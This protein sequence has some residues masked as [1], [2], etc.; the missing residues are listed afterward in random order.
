MTKNEELIKLITEYHQLISQEDFEKIEDLC[1]D[2]DIV[3]ACEDII[4]DSNIKMFEGKGFDSPGYDCNS[5]FF[6]WIENNK[7]EGIVLNH[8]SF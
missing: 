8:E 7:I 5:Y 3:N 2:G 6:A 4:V 1:E